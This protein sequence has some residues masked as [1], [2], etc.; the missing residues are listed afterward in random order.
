M[1]RYVIDPSWFARSVAIFCA[2]LAVPATTLS[3]VVLLN[4]GSVIEGAAAF[5]GDSVVVTLPS[6]AVLRLREVEVAVVR[7]SLV[8]AYEWM[9]S[10]R[11]ATTAE[12]HLRRA[13]WC[14]RHELWPEAALSLLEARQ[15]Q[16][17]P[18]RVDLLERR[19]AEVS[20]RPAGTP[21]PSEG[22]KPAPSQPTQRRAPLD[23][24]V[25]PDV[26]ESFARRVEPL[27]VNNCAAS[28]CHSRGDRFELDRS[29]LHGYADSRSMRRNLRAVLTVIDVDHPADSLLLAAARGHHA[30]VTPFG[31]PRRL[32][33]L[34]R[35]EAWVAA[36]AAAQ[37]AT[38][39]PLP[40][41]PGPAVQPALTASSTT[42]TVSAP[43]LSET[44]LPYQPTVRRGVT[45]RPLEP[46]DEFDPRIFNDRHRR[47]I[48]DTPIA[49]P[50]AAAG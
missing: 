47:P 46:R 32:E 19:L 12:D 38:E 40:P 15:S 18:R 21:S 6:E 39:L 22:N 17:D 45:L 2:L 37:P 49:S 9:V 4:N 23:L 31:G 36:V 27:L 13:E 44:E 30:G 34:A 10:Q 16:A 8:A 14:L 33:W 41:S 50:S 26:L 5:D 28:G 48:D 29:R 20:R 11:P 25:P 1:A 35:L 3:D 43:T 7:P 24:A 42:E